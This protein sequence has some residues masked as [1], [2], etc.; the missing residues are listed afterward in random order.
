MTTKPRI[1]LRAA[2]VPFFEGM[3][4]SLRSLDIPFGRCEGVGPFR[5]CCEALDT[6]EILVE[7]PDPGRF[8]DAVREFYGS[9]R[10]KTLAPERLELHLT[11]VGRELGQPMPFRIEAT[12]TESWG[13]RL[14]CLT[15]P[16]E[17][18]RSVLDRAAVSGITIS[19]DPHADSAAGSFFAADENAVYAAAGLPWIPPE[20]RDI[21]DSLLWAG[22]NRLPEL[23]RREDIRG[24]LHLHTTWSDGVNSLEEMAEAA[25]SRGLRYIA[26]TDH[27]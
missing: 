4:R 24:D 7:T 26:V 8:T 22:E 16:Q 3:V 27:T 17:H 21:P 1:H 10:V 9:D 11:T 2:C 25:R 18:V 5:R 23:I 14:F 20:I 12:L 15:G 19:L 6:L 13:N